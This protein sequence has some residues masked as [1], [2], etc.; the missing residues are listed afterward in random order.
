M[1]DR[2]L[3]YRI[4]TANAT[5][6]ASFAA[7][8]LSWWAAAGDGFSF[9]SAGGLAATAAVAYIL[10][11]TNNRHT[12]L[13]VRSMSLPATF[14]LLSGALTFL[15]PLSLGYVPE[16]C[17]AAALPVLFQ[18]YQNR[19][20]QAYVFYLFLLIGVGALV[21]PQM[22]L[23]APFLLFSV[24]AQMRAMTLRAFFAAVIGAALPF[25]L[26]ETYLMLA[27]SG[28]MAY[29]FWE[30]LRYFPKPDYAAAGGCRL[31]SFATVALLAACA[32]AHFA[33]AKFNDKIRTRSLYYAV[34]TG[35]LGIT[36][37][38][39]AR[40]G[41]FDTIFRLFALNSAPLIAHHLTFAEGK[42]GNIY[43][44]TA[45]ALILLLAACNIQGI[46]A[47]LWGILPNI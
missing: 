27:G 9:R 31:V 14:L 17:W 13:R 20:A 22:L 10:A 1:N 34:M 36:A 32:A 40:P 38:L 21:F 12:L 33:R 8:S 5:L 47:T 35:E 25:A 7:A 15:H 45:L 3:R 41:E 43:F 19:E 44:C 26:R 39:A 29:D 16:V 24:A 11:E 30:R 6:F 46:N 4:I 37:L 18:C 28:T 23:L 2:G 42:S